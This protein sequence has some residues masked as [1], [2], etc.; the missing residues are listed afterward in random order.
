MLLLIFGCLTAWAIIVF[1]FSPIQCCIRR[2]KKDMRDNPNRWAHLK[3]KTWADI[4]V[5]INAPLNQEEPSREEFFNNRIKN[6][7]N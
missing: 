4:G 1:E 7:H 2:H 5:D 6:Y 3:G